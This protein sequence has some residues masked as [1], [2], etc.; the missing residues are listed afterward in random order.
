MQNITIIGYLGADPEMKYTQDGQPV[1][2][3]S[4]AVNDPRAEE[5]E[6]PTWY[7]VA[8]WGKSAE[9]A[10]EFLKSGHR[11]AVIGSLRIRGY[12]DKDNYQAWSNDVNANVVE[13]LT[14]KDSADPGERRP[15]QTAPAR[16]PAAGSQPGPEEPPE[17]PPE[18]EAPATTARRPRA[19]PKAR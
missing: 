7:R 1:T 17:E 5:G 4:V 6:A 12:E 18:E 15:S 9:A 11:V 3:F 10:N 16:R 13:Y 19:A 14:P 2:N 8:T